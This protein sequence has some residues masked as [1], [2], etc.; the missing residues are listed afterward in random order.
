MYNRKNQNIA[1]TKFKPKPEE[2]VRDDA[3]TLITGWARDGYTLRDMAEAIGISQCMFTQWRKKYPEIEQA[4]VDGTEIVDYKVENALLKAALGYKTK[5]VRVCTTLINGKVTQTEN[6]TITKEVAPSV[7]AIQVWLYN[8]LPDKWRKNRDDNF[9]SSDEDNRIQI[10]VTRAMPS[11]NVEETEVWD[12]NKNNGELINHSVEVRPLTREERLERR[13]K[14]MAEKRKPKKKKEME[15]EE[16]KKSA[17]NDAKNTKDV[18][19]LKNNGDFD[20]KEDLDY[21]PD[22]WQDDED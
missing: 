19:F 15:E 7:S 4:I 20:E 2:W 11:E 22:D 12:E 21:W 10:T 13:K 8:R 17:K 14:A 5:E 18:D 3:L 6:E 16:K 1:F 9:L